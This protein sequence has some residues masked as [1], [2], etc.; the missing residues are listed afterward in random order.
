MIS[1]FNDGLKRF[2]GQDKGGVLRS[3]DFAVDGLSKKPVEDSGG[4]S[5]HDIVN[6]KGVVMNGPA[7][8]KDMEKIDE[9]RRIKDLMEDYQELVDENKALTSSVK[10]LEDELDSLRDR[11]VESESVRAVL[12]KKTVINDPSRLV[13]PE[14]LDLNNQRILDALGYKPKPF[15]PGKITLPAPHSSW[16]KQVR[17]Y[18]H[19]RDELEGYLKGVAQQA[20]RSGSLGKLSF[21]EAFNEAVVLA[22]GQEFLAAFKRVEDVGVKMIEYVNDLTA[23]FGAVV[24][25]KNLALDECERRHGMLDR[26]YTGV[27]GFDGVGVLDDDFGSSSVLDDPVGAGRKALEDIGRGE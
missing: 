9:D 4:D 25:L 6:G 13:D 10:S 2:V 14:R 16:L 3:E 15:K 5:L 12:E 1:K 8:G 11:L 17:D 20:L 18:E 23:C 27:A 21:L 22:D 19:E 24:G 7:K 26:F